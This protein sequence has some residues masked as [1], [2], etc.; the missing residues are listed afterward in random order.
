ML[1]I[2]RHEGPS[3]SWEEEAEGSQQHEDA[4]VERRGWTLGKAVQEHFLESI[5]SRL[6]PASISAL[7]K[8]QL[9]LLQKMLIANTLSASIRCCSDYLIMHNST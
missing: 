8:A 7:K 1:D 6:C 9:D 4:R 5:Q 2:Q 3:P